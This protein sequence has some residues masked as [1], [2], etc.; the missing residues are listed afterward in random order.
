MLSYFRI[1]FGTTSTSATVSLPT[2]AAAAHAER[3][4][5]S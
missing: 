1:T 4:A 3:L 5:T 2:I